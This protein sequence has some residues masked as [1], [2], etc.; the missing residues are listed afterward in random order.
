MAEEYGFQVEHFSFNDHLELYFFLLPTIN[1]NL[2]LYFIVVTV[3]LTEKIYGSGYVTTT[4]W[5]NYHANKQSCK[6]LCNY[7]DI[8]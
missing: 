2:Y 4:Q 7:E 8:R 6:F 1:L 3:S 5:Q